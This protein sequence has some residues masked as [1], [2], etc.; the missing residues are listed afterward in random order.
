MLHQGGMPSHSP[1]HAALQSCGE[2]NT[3]GGGNFLHRK[4][5]IMPSSSVITWVSKVIFVS[6][7]RVVSYICVSVSKSGRRSLIC[8]VV[9]GCFNVPSQEK[10]SA[11]DDL[12][13][14]SPE[15]LAS[16]DE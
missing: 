10:Q 14:E 6:I 4:S 5:A 1:R 13:Q 9:R 15:W 7:G 2:L 12:G 8:N 3:F 16:R 11:P